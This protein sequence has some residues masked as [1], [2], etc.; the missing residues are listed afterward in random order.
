MAAW[1]HNSTCV[2]KKFYINMIIL[3]K[4]NSQWLKFVYEKIKNSMIK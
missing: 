3:D 2:F 4:L 1:K